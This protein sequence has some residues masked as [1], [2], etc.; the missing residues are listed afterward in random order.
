M[1]EELWGRGFYFSANHAHRLWSLPN[2][3]FSEFWGA[4]LGGKAAGS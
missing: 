1:T 4:F 3:V 2:Y